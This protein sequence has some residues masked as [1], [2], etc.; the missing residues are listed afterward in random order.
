MKQVRGVFCLLVLLT[1]LIA[2]CGGSS[3]DD[4]VNTGNE[5]G[6]T[7]KVSGLACKGLVRGGEVIVYAVVDGEKGEVLA[8]AVTG[9]DGS[10]SADIGDYTGPVIIEV[11]GGTYRDE[12]TGEEVPLK[13]TLRAALAEAE[14]VVTAAVTPLTELAVSLAHRAGFT[15]DAIQAANDRFSQLLGEGRSIVET[16]PRDVMT[17]GAEG[18][19][20]AYGLLLAG[21]AEMAQGE[22]GGVAKALEQLEKDLSD[23]RIDELADA[24]T[25]GIDDFLNGPHNKTGVTDIPGGLD[26]AIAEIKERGFAPTGEL[27]ELQERLIALLALGPDSPLFEAKLDKFF[28]YMGEFVAETPEAHLYK[29]VAI[30]ADLYNDESLDELKDLGLDWDMDP[31]FFADQ[32]KMKALSEKLLE[33]RLDGSAIGLK[34]TLRPLTEKLSAALA[35]L[36]LAEGAR[37]C[38]SITGIDTVSIDAVDIDL[39][40]GALSLAKAC[41]LYLEAVD[42][43]VETWDV[44]VG[45][46]SVDI[47]D[48]DLGALGDKDAAAHRAAFLDA[49]PRL[50]TYGDSRAGLVPF[51]ES[52]EQA[53]SYVAAAIARLDAMG[54]A[55][56]R[57]RFGH[58]LTYDSEQ[59]FYTMKAMVEVVLP[60]IAE[61]W[62]LEA[63]TE[64]TTLDAEDASPAVDVFVAEDGYAYVRRFSDIYAVT[65]DASNGFNLYALL[66]QAGTLTPRACLALDSPFYVEKPGTRELLYPKVPEVDWDEPMDVV[67]VPVVAGLAV[68][69][70]PADW[71]GVAR[72]WRI[73]RGG[74][75]VTVKLALD[76]AGRLYAAL[77]GEPE[78]YD[79]FYAGVHLWDAADG[80]DK[81]GGLTVEH[82]AT[83]DPDTPRRFAA[84]WYYSMSA[85]GLLEK[86]AFSNGQGVVVGGEVV[87]P[88]DLSEAMTGLNMVGQFSSWLILTP[89]GEA[90]YHGRQVVLV[91]ETE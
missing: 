31:D 16:L 70:D 18:G 24:L 53:G 20:V 46:A 87:L 60:S 41:C 91:P 52:W 80:W 63:V 75:E 9:D 35:E 43:T 29:A 45:E 36:T 81:Y 42:L 13:M 82:V 12:A 68:D 6:A 3:G 32:T 7:T 61:A 67:T 1:L 38:I 71:G 21:L 78:G 34:K 65:C 56:R 39:M 59:A 10:Y 30:L 79:E 14:G 37:A 50:L 76:D 62:G 86:Q 74:A 11:V 33:A 88:S 27:K 66:N 2:S 77:E 23:G 58:A 69:G 54:E 84:S 48:V 72:A 64:I 83:G 47:R 57:G 28:V 4:P 90:I 8:K 25:D 5:P 51:K 44:T 15:P 17:E 26:S 49:N 73:A 22:A 89:E 55:G 85:G 40:R 19:D